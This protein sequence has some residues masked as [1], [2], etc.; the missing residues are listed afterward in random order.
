M[1]HLPDSEH[2]HEV[3]IERM[4][5]HY[6]FLNKYFPADLPII[7][8]LGNHGRAPAGRRH[9]DHRALTVEGERRS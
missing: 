9:T 8:V 6:G 7:P 2:S 4:K 1:A 5:T 3:V